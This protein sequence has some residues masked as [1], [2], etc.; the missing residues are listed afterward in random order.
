MHESTQCV[1]THLLVLFLPNEPQKFRR[2]EQIGREEGLIDA[3]VK[4]VHEFVPRLLEVLP[5]FGE[6]RLDRSTALTHQLVE[7]S[8]LDEIRI[9]F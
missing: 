6:Q 9:W 7:D 3:P 4:L 1:R 5:H 8:Q 2:V